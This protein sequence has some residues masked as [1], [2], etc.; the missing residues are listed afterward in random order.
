MGLYLTWNLRKKTKQDKTENITGVSKNTTCIYDSVTLL[1][2]AT[3]ETTKQQD[4]L[5]N[6]AHWNL[7]V[8]LRMRCAWLC[9]LDVLNVRSYVY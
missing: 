2:V 1:L 4:N 3:S 7:K 5:A 9:S 6:N 8:L